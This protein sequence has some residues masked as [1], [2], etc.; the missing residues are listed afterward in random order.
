MQ[1]GQTATEQDILKLEKTV[2][3]IPGFINGATIVGKALGYRAKVDRLS[4]AVLFNKTTNFT[5][6]VKTALQ[7]D[8]K[9]ISIVVTINGNYEASTATAVMEKIIADFKTALAKQFAN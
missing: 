4:N 2:A 7:D 9:T 1:T 6:F 3:P 5:T 8:D